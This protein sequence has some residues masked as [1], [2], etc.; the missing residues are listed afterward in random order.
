MP[1]ACGGIDFVGKYGAHPPCSGRHLIVWLGGS[2]HKMV[3]KVNRCVGYAQVRSPREHW[4]P[5]LAT[6]AGSLRGSECSGGPGP[7]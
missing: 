7:L 1:W 3:L 2:G 6:E 4:F 5:T